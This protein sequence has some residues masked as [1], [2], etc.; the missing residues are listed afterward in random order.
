MELSEIL[1][2]RIDKNHTL[3]NR[4]CLKYIRRPEW[5]EECLQEGFEKFLNCGRSFGSFKE[6]EKYLLIGKKLCD[7]INWF[8]VSAEAHT[9]LAKTYFNIGEYQPRSLKKNRYVLYLR[10]LISAGA[11]RR[12]Q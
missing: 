3:Y 8:L 7:R 12:V 4:Y 10:D 5:V 2:E 6:A 1:N 9:F 11:A